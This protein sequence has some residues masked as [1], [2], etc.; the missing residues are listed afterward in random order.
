M[1]REFD[2]GNE[3]RTYIGL[4]ESVTDLTPIRNDKIHILCCVKVPGFEMTIPY[5]PPGPQISADGE[6]LTCAEVPLS[7][8]CLVYSFSTR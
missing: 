5:S 7:S 2:D 3:F 8:P 4:N 6:Y 1:I